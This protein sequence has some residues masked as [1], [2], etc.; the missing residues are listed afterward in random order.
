MSA[1]IKSGTARVLAVAVPVVLVVLAIGVFLVG[2]SRAQG[3]HEQ[4]LRV[5]DQRGGSHALLAAAGELDNVP[6]KIEW[7]QMPAAAPLLEALS[8]GAIDI[9]SSSAPP[10]IYAYASGAQIRAILATQVVETGPNEGRS[11]GI[12]VPK[13]SPLRTAAD[14]RGKKIATVKG[15]IGQDTALKILEHAG[16]ASKEVQFVYLNNG[17]AKAA[18]ASGAIDA[19]STWGNYVG[20]AVV[21]D[22]DRL[23][24]DAHGLGNRNGRVRHGQHQGAGLQEAADPRLSAA[25]YPRPPMGPD[26]RSRTGLQKSKETGVPL[27]GQPL[28]NRRRFDHRTGHHRRQHHQGSAPDLRTL[29]ARGRH[30]QDSGTWARAATTPR[31][32][33]SS[34]PPTGRP[35]TRR[36]PPTADFPIRRRRVFRLC[37]KTGPDR[38]RNDLAVHP[39]PAD[40][41]GRR[42][43]SGPPSE[44]ADA[45]RRA[46]RRSACRSARPA[47][48]MGPAFSPAIGSPAADKKSPGQ[49]RPGQV[50]GQVRVGRG[51]LEVHLR[52]EHE[53]ARVAGL[54]RGRA[55]VPVPLA[56]DV[57]DPATQGDRG[58][59]DLEIVAAPRSTVAY[60]GISSVL[61]AL[62]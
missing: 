2:R 54:D 59:V 10:F 4:V 1:F 60:P 40:R 50:Q 16:V 39:S 55:V 6:Y 29:Q 52:R 58:L 45:D 26:P 49:E 3:G 30:R 13:N 61:L 41:A 23:L 8:A 38:I 25:L 62:P 42:R 12:L 32:T 47:R 20:I 56:G 17:D 43:L 19:W 31:S 37:S 21:E 48:S 24:A 15:S 36:S 51:W 9:G 44:T 35:R 53:G 33:T 7:A 27:G 11:T 46:L 34:S 57:L 28:W 14:L 18:L 22:G 5:G